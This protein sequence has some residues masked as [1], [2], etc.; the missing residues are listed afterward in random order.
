MVGILV[1]KHVV[2]GSADFQVIFQYFIL[3]EGKMSLKTK[4]VTF[5]NYFVFHFI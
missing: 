3:L 1:L 5:Y 2:I 4:L